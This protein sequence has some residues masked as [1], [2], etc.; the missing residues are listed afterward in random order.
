MTVT[1]YGADFS[2]YT[3]SVRMTLFEKDIAYTLATVDPFEGDVREHLMRNP[4]GKVPV[5]DWDGFQIY[6]TSAILRFIDAQKSSP[7]LVPD[8]AEVCARMEQIFS[9]CD[10]YGFGAM[11]W[12]VYVEGTQKPSDFEPF[13]PDLVTKGLWETKRILKAIEDLAGPGPYLV[14]ADVSL[15]DLHFASMIAYL[16]MSKDGAAVFDQSGRLKEWWDAMAAR[17]SVIE[18]QYPIETGG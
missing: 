16:K 4:F 11:V 9:I 18:T 7:P 8:D 6:E 17:P 13:D 5:L 2:V 10:S 15:A 3:R 12:S 1:V 14:G